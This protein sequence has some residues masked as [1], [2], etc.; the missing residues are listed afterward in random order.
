MY[1]CVN[2]VLCLHECLLDG[3]GD[4]EDEDVMEGEEFDE[5]RTESSGE[6]EE[7]AEKVSQQSQL[8]SEPKCTTGGPQTEPATSLPLAASVSQVI[9]PNH[10]LS[11]QLC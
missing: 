9:A 1:C 6:E 4:E 5:V 3:E 8:D 11:Y 10:S 2:L 7:V